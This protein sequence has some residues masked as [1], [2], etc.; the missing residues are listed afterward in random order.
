MVNKFAQDYM[1]ATSV[2]PVPK[3]MLPASA[4]PGQTGL[5]VNMVF[6]YC[7]SL[8]WVFSVSFSISLHLYINQSL[9][10]PG[11]SFVFPITPTALHP[12]PW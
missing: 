1:A 2:S 4:C 7:L 11:T 12:T 9:P 8:G 5:K 10:L 3:Q 6:C